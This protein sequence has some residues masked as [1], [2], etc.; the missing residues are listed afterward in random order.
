MRQIINLTHPLESWMPVYPGTPDAEVAPLRTH[1]EDGFSEHTLFFT[2]HTGTHMD[3]PYHM[4]E[5]GKRL[6]D[7]DGGIFVG[8]AIVLDMKTQGTVQALQEVELDDVDFILFQTG[9]TKYWKTEAYFGE[10]PVLSKD[11]I[12]Y[13]AKSNIRGIGIDTPSVDPIETEDYENH[14][15]LFEKDKVI[16][17]NLTTLDKLPNTPFEFIAAPIYYKGADGA[18]IR[19][20]AQIEI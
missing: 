8:T 4:K 3:A 15:L 14:H 10:Y 12:E 11:A 6:E 1:A 9:H 13:L 5:N 19:A 17:E 18:P 20:F 7:I 16:F 2:T